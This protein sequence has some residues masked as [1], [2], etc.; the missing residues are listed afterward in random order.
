MTAMRLVLMAA[1]AVR[2]QSVPDGFDPNASDFI[3]V[4]VQPDGKIRGLAF[5]RPESPDELSHRMLTFAERVAYQRAIEEVYWRYRIWPTENAGPKPLLDEVVSPAQIQQK[6]KDY[7]RNSQL[8]SN[9][10]HRPI[11]PEQLQAEMERMASQTKQSEVLQDLF[12]ALGND[13]ALVAECLVRPVLAERLVREVYAQDEK[14]HGELERRAEKDLRA[15]KSAEDMKRTSAVYSEMEWIRSDTFDLASK[16][17]MEAVR[18][19]TVEWDENIKKLATEF[20]G[21]ET[22]T[23]SPRLLGKMSARGTQRAD[24]NRNNAC[25]EGLARIRIGVMSLLQEDDSRYFATQVLDKG[26]NRIKIATIAWQKEPFESWARR[27]DAGQGET[28][29]ESTAHYALPPIAIRAIGCMPDSWTAMTGAPDRRYSHT[30]VWTG[31]EM[32]VWGGTAAA[33]SLALGS[34]GRYNPDTNSWVPTAT[35]GVP[36]ARMSHTAVWTGTEMIVWGGS[37]GL[38]HYFNTGGRYD[39][40]TDSWTPTSTSGAPVDLYY[41]T[42]VWT[43]SEMIVWGGSGGGNGGRYNPTA[44]SWIATSTGKRAHLPLRSHG[45]LDRQ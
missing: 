5:V 18:M 7:L 41:P 8:L 30:A 10:W 4:V 3:R 9:Q 38:H 17:E 28:R 11:T 21:Q 25:A 23:K 1:A 2:G 45:R 12:A 22:A 37:D 24:V 35:T 33:N 32:I 44:D 15:L 20:K 39:P 31:N 6:V 42:A 19:T 16:S 43:G 13:P 40:S 26:P 36:T 34:G 29:I 14:L 27:A